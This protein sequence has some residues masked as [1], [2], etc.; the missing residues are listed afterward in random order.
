VDNVNPNSTN[1][2]LPVARVRERRVA[3]ASRHFTL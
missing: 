1:H 3:R 2:N